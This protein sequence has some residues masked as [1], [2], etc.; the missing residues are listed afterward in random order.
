[1]HGTCMWSRFRFEQYHALTKSINH[2]LQA[3]H[4]WTA[5]FTSLGAKD[6]PVTDLLSREC[7]QRS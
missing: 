5:A 1:M 6:S 3:C 7:D 4:V 2:I